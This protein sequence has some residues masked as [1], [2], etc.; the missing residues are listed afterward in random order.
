MGQ[1]VFL[2]IAAL[3]LGSLLRKLK[4]PGAMLIAGTFVTAAWSILIGPVS[5]PPLTKTA[6]Q[7][8]AG[9]FVG[10]S[11][12]K[13]DVFRL[14]KLIG[15]LVLLVSAYFMAAVTMGL[16]IYAVCPVGLL[17]ALLCVT[18][19]GITDMTL[20]S[21]DLGADA[22]KVAALQ[23]F[24]NV[25]G[26]GVYPPLIRLLC[27]QEGT[28]TDSAAPGRPVKSEKAGV[29][30]QLRTVAIAVLLAYL[31]MLSRV[32]AGGF[33]FAL[34]GI[35]ILNLA[36]RP[37][38]S[39]SPGLR[40]LA[41]LLSGIYVGS[42]VR[43]RGILE[44]RHMLLPVL[45]VSVG[46]F[47]FCLFGGRALTRFFGMGKAEGMLAATAAGASD[48]ALISADLGVQSTDLVSLQIMRWVVVTALFPQ[49]MLWLS[50][51]VG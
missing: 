50:Q 18:P 36:G 6:A 37:K 3:L 38:L 27:R 51:F 20:I 45:I 17:T 14:K 8:I 30:V 40:Y 32:K 33:L 26:V 11:I 31:G 46:Y 49:A 9:A 22:V 1:F 12:C 15:P 4:I 39:L 10:I 29:P 5:V 25:V 42:G 23:F 2:A 43:Y 16:L 34:F 48:M 19:A 21:E 24:R 7:A 28:E 35:A 41:Q 47:L 13:E 44:L